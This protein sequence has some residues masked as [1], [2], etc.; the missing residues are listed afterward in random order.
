MKLSKE[1]IRECAAWVEENGL[2]PQR[3]GASVKLFCEAMGISF[4][5]YKRWQENV[6]FV[7]AIT[8]AREVFQQRTVQEVANALVKAAKGYEFVKTKTEG[9]PQVVTEYDPSTGKKVKTY[10]TD[11]II[12]V[13]ST[14]E[15]IQVE[16]SVA[17]A[18]FLLT[19]MDPENWKNKKDTTA[20][21]NLGFEEAPVIVFSDSPSEPPAG[22]AVPGDGPVPTEEQ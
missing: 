9:K 2:Y 12:P 20:D 1:K 5:T 13:K 4:I 22:D 11:K 17:A 18:T 16:P 19:N 8:H 3:C 21:L 15:V 6:N 10:Q 14:R 7:D